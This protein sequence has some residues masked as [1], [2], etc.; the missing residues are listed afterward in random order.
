MHSSR[1]GRVLR[2]LRRWPDIN[3]IPA[4]LDGPSSLERQSLGFANEHGVFCCHHTSTPRVELCALATI[5][6]Y[7][8]LVCGGLTLKNVLTPA[9]LISTISH[10]YHTV[11]LQNLNTIAKQVLLVGERDKCLNSA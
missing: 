8:Q 1:P 6:W 5:F 4:P 11:D 3:L 2:L 10:D 9:P 7:C